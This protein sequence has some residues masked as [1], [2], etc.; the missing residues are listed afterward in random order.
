M[1][2]HSTSS[3]NAAKERYRVAPLPAQNQR[4]ARRNR[5]NR[6]TR[7]GSRPRGRCPAGQGDCKHTTC[8]ASAGRRSRTP[9]PSASARRPAAAGVGAKPIE[10]KQQT[11]TSGMSQPHATGSNASAPARPPPTAIQY[12]R[13]RAARPNGRAKPRQ[14]ALLRWLLLRSW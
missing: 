4:R 1:R 3:H 9:T 7:R 12:E 10:M 11:G 14:T 13:S 5:P 6:C 8:R 2:N